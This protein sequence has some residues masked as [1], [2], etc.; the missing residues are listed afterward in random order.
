VL[1]DEEVEVVQEPTRAGVRIEKDK[2][3]RLSISVP[4][5]R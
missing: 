1:Y 5:Y 4:R 3:G 2:R